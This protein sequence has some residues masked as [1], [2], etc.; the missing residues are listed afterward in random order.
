MFD[1]D[2][3]NA[4]VISEFRANGGK[5]ARFGELPVVILHTIG[6]KS[7]KVREIPL[8]VVQDGDEMLL[9]GTKAGS[10]THPVWY[11]NLRAHPRITIEFGEGRFTANVLELPEAEA[12]GKVRQMAEANDQFA[13]Y[14]KSAAPRRIP[15][16]SIVRI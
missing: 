11:Y 2:T 15:V 9:F 3:L 16:F 14:M 13:D 8:I 12:D 7:G 4:E 6:A 5:V 1:W 10:P